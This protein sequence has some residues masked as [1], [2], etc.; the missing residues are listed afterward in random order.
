MSSQTDIKIH[1]ITSI[2]ELSIM[3]NCTARNI[4]S[5]GIQIAI[6]EFKKNLHL[7]IAC[8]RSHLKVSQKFD[9]VKLIL[10]ITA[11]RAE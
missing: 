3:L 1:A 2:A 9:I 4:K 10:F 8:L 5:I 11:S 6:N 7:I